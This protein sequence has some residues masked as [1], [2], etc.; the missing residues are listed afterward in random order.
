MMAKQRCSLLPYC[1][2][3]PRRRRQHRGQLCNTA[4]ALFAVVLLLVDPSEIVFQAEFRAPLTVSVEEPLFGVSL[5]AG[6]RARNRVNKLFLRLIVQQRLTARA[7][8]SPVTVGG[9]W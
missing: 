3:Y 6:L 5:D 2:P 4:H 1:L 9:R 8:A 7:S